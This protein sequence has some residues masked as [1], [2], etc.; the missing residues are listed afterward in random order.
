MRAALQIHSVYGDTVVCHKMIGSFPWKQHRISRAQHLRFVWAQ[1]TN[2]CYQFE[3]RYKL[4]LN[5][6]HRTMATFKK[7]KT[8]SI[9][10]GIKRIRKVLGPH[11]RQR[12][13]NT[14]EWSTSNPHVEHFE[15]IEFINSIEPQAD[16]PLGNVA[17]QFRI[18]RLLMRW[19]IETAIKF[20]EEMLLDTFEEQIPLLSET[21]TTFNELI[22]MS[23]AHQVTIKEGEI[24]ATRQ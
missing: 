13:Q 17:G 14:H 3:E 21:A 23:K 20:M 18:T 9:S 19:E 24:T 2:L 10:D 4:F 12:G 15:T 22:E 7:K 6:Q 8:A 11:I 16:G 1:F 5:L